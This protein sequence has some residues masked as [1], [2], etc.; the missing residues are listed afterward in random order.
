MKLFK[1]L[2]NNFLLA[3]LFAVALVITGTVNAHPI[4][5][6]SFIVGGG[7]VV[8]T[9]GALA[10]GQTVQ[11]FL[12]MAIQKEI[13]TDYLLENLYKAN[14]FLQYC[15]RADQWVLAGK[16][17]HIPTA[18]AKP[19]VVKNRSSLPASVTQ[20][21]DI[22][23]TYALDEFTT[24]PILIPD[25]E[26]VELS[27]DK[28]DNV[29]NEHSQALNELIGD[30]ILIKWAKST[31]GATT[32]ATLLRTTGGPVAAH[33]PSATGNRNKFVKEDLK[34]ARTAMNK[35]NIPQGDRYALI[36]SDM[37]SQL[38]EDSD[39]M[40]RDN[41][42]ELI[43]KDGVIM[44]LYGFN[45]IERSHVLVFDNAGT[46]AVKALGAAA[47]ATDNAAVLC[48]QKNSVEAA[49]GEVKFFED[50]QNPTYY[51]DIYSALMRASGRIR[52]AAGVVTIVQ[53]ANP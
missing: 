4:A 19:T 20:R 15:F 1:N 17:V 2:A 36:D 16:V 28:V 23:I 35:A 14:V 6:A 37:M 33:L 30:D 53:Q 8:N 32:T 27:Y 5:I 40:K 22:D 13:W 34:A 3:A 38:L 25:A 50:E 43:V 49:I 7:I 39:L 24:D 21:T 31:G 48:W 12:P 42:Q 45:L 41:S 26:T 18:G 52:R 47:A 51:G 9:I 46:P 10:G 11:N 29:M 44:K